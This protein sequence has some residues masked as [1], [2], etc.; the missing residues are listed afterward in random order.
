MK[1]LS[2]NETKRKQMLLAGGAGV[3]LISLLV[4]GL[5][6]TDPNKDQPSLREKQREQAAEVTKSFRT[7][8]A[9]SAEETWIA[10]SEEKIA[11]LENKNR[12]VTTAMRN[13]RTSLAE[14]GIDVGALAKQSQ[15]KPGAGTPGAEE[16][17]AGLPIPNLKPKPPDPLPLL[18]T[19]EPPTVN[20]PLPAIPALPSPLPPGQGTRLI[21]PA[22]NVAGQPDKTSPQQQ[23]GEIHMVTVGNRPAG[24]GD[25]KNVKQYIPAGSFASVRLLSG[26]DAP[27]GGAANANPIPVLL[28]VMTDGT[29]PNFFHSNVSSCHV[30]A[31]AHGE[32]SS[33]R[34]HIQLERISCVLLNGNAIETQVK[35]YITG[36]DGKAGMRGR[37]VSKQGSLIARSLLTGLASGF[38]RTLQQQ[39]Q[40][41]ATS[42]LGAVATVDPNRVLQAGAGAGISTALEK[43]ADYYLQRANEIYPIIEIA[44]NREGEAILQ[45]GVSLDQPI[46]HNTREGEDLL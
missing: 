31:S 5:W 12:D 27:T 43:I 14:L 16:E 22:R 37:L 41:L 7:K 35:G 15:E 38:G 9:V 18:K 33:E 24:D 25:A 8:K 44:A 4:F 17:E 21:T 32:I 46:L 10:K 3:G 39:S 40:Q 29:L 2:A 6:F 11:E 45:E 28:R 26:V 1:L 19:P 42:P 30:V 13:I 23:N 20:P 34:A 36:E